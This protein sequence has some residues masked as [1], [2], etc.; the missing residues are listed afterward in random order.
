MSVNALEP[1]NLAVF[2]KSPR[3][4]GNNELKRLRITRK[5]IANPEEFF[6]AQRPVQFKWKYCERLNQTLDEHDVDDL[7][8]GGEQV[9]KISRLIKR[10]VLTDHHRPD[11]DLETSSSAANLL[12]YAILEAMG[13]RVKEKQDLLVRHEFSMTMNGSRIPTEVDVCVVSYTWSYLLFLVVQD[14]L[15]PNTLLVPFAELM[16]VCIA[17]FQW[18]NKLRACHGLDPLPVMVSVPLCRGPK[19]CINILAVDLPSNDIERHESSLLYRKN[20]PG[21]F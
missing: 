10:V 4:W 15:K 1:K 3:D 11:H 21:S 13:F 12:V 6:P 7:V 2:A 19:K 18:N 16:G 14:K 9:L 5:R 17:A 8:A 20:H